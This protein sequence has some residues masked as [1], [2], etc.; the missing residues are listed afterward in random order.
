MTSQP[1]LVYSGEGDSINASSDSENCQ[2]TVVS[3]KP[4]TRNG[5]PVNYPEPDSVALSVHCTT[6]SRSLQTL[7]KGAVVAT[8]AMGNP[9]V[10]LGSSTPVSNDTSVDT[11]DTQNIAA[12]TTPR[13]ATNGVLILRYS[14]ATQQ[15]P[16]S[17]QSASATEGGHAGTN[18]PVSVMEKNIEDGHPELKRQPSP[19]QTVDEDNSICDREDALDRKLTKL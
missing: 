11:L 2:A 5:G 9:N 4:R 3:C 6:V 18:R 10:R 19:D 16:S 12:T 8:R 13:P 15:S 1:R 7:G 17:K 14:V